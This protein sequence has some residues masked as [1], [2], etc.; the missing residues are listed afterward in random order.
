MYCDVP[1]HLIHHDHDT[2]MFGV[3]MEATITIYN[4]II[5]VLPVAPF[6]KNVLVYKQKEYNFTI[7]KLI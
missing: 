5:F 7:I 3:F 6:L 2:V 4:I 1:R